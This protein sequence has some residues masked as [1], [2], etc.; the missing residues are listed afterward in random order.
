MILLE[1]FT[2]F[3]RMGLFNFGGG[4]AMISLM[5][6]V[7]VGHGWIT[8]PEFAD[9]VAVSQMTPGPLAVNLATYAGFRTAG[10]AGA[11]VATLGVFLPSLIICVLVASMLRKF[12]RN[13]P[14]QAVM[15]GVKPA[16]VALVAMACL[17]MAGV[18]VFSQALPLDSLVRGDLGAWV[19]LQVSW[20]GLVIC[21]LVALLHGV[22]KVD[23]LLLILGAALA[24]ML[25]M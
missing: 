9:M 19:G 14:F 11:A 12:S 21:G 8:G 3:F 10:L 16:V 1:L 17:F 25:V 5:E 7:V 22:A 13:Q 6:Q 2:A 15:S 18:S 20:P 4:Y 24:G 23:A